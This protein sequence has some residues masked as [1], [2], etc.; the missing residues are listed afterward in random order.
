MRLF[1]LH[2]TARLGAAV[3]KA[4]G[5]ELSPLEEREFADGEHKSRPLVSVRGEDVYLLSSLHGGAVRSPADKLLRLV[6]LAATCR[7]N[8]ADRVTLLVPYMAYM[9]KD[10]QTK[11]RDPVTSRYVATVIEAAQPDM[12]VALDVH[13]PAAFQNGFRCRTTHLTMAEFFADHL[14]QGMDKTQVVLMSPD[15]G[16][17]RRTHHLMQA[18]CAD[19]ARAASF[20]MMEKHR[21][22]GRVTGDLFAGSV[23]DCN[24]IIVD[25]L[26]S[27]GGTILRAARACRDR[28]ASTVTAVATHG[29]F[30][31]GAAE[32][33]S[34]AAVDRVIVSDSAMP[35]QLGPEHTAPK[36]EVVSA[37]P[38][39]A[40]AMQRLHGGGSI[41]RLLSPAR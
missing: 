18:Y 21:S 16:G 13:N 9:R 15:S 35:F 10:Q 14:A 28:G 36:L 34:D 25:D 38:L 3:A 29:L 23:Q 2:D 32:L 41:H 1:A 24:V 30:S 40:S 37:A 33:F 5:I 20:A 31:N 27:T 17:I 39:L 4:A 7:D 6:F 26:I 8:G 12:V 11:P 19:A 22:E